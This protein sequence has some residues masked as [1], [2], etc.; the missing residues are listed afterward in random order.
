MLILAHSSVFGGGKVSFSVSD[1]CGAILATP[2]SIRSR[3]ARNRRHYERYMVHNIEC[4]HAVTE[5]IGYPVRLEDLMLVTGVDLTKSWS[6]AVFTERQIE[7]AVGLEVDYATVGSLKWASRFRWRNTHGAQVNWGPQPEQDMTYI[8]SGE[9]WDR[10]S[11]FTT[12][13]PSL[14]DSLSLA[15]RKEDQAI[16]I[17]RL[18]VKKRVLFRGL[19]IQANAKP[20]DLGDDDPD[21]SDGSGSLFTID[22]SPE[23]TDVRLSLPLRNIHQLTP[24]VVFG[25]SHTH[26]GFYPRSAQVMTKLVRC[27]HI[28]KTVTEFGC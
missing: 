6:T 25:C 13:T 8:S 28:L 20:E 1:E 26:P 4:W 2:D 7:G 19:K 15:N 12:S 27:G 9:S 17:R 10:Q 24:P 23:H 14:A 21:S 11:T 22:R 16:F 3:D 18:R 5:R